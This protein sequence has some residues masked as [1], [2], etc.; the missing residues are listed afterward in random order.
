[1]NKLSIKQQQAL[2]YR[3]LRNAGLTTL[4][5]SLYVILYSMYQVT[6]NPLVDTAAI[7]VVFTWGTLI[8]L[9][10][11]VSLFSIRNK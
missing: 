5:A 4:F 9:F 10:S 1:M 11:I 3:K 6:F 8:G 7:L 2:Q